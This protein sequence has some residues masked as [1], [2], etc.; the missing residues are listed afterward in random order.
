MPGGQSWKDE[1]GVP[2]GAE[3]K[4]RGS[5]GRAGRR[6]G[7]WGAGRAR[8]RGPD[9]ADGPS[10]LSGAIDGT[11]TWT[12]SLLASSVDAIK[13]SIA[14][15]KGSLCRRSDWSRRERRPPEALLAK[16]RLLARGF[17]GKAWAGRLEAERGSFSRFLVSAAQEIPP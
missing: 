12:G 3:L 1:E 16:P 10:R 14:G 8:R 2:G 9:A 15:M 4:D 5:G 7:P 11:D 6:G 17:G 13:E